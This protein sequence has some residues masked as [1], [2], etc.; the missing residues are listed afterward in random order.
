MTFGPFLADRTRLARAYA[1]A[2]C[3]VV[4]GAHETFGLAALEA[5]A[6]GARVVVSD[7]C[8]AGG[9]VAPVASV[10]AAGNPAAL[11]RAIERARL[12]LPDPAAARAI[13][14]AHRWDRAFMAELADLERLVAP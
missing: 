8:P 4:P 2:R 5:A 11:A 9:S 10:F 3:V 7:T 13:A 14:D 12:R 6:C 1:A